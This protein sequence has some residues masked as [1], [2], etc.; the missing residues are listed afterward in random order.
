MELCDKLSISAK[1]NKH[2]LSVKPCCIIKKI[3]FKKILLS[4][5]VFMMLTFSFVP[6]AY[7][8]AETGKWYG[9]SF[10]EWFTK[11]DDSPE[12]EIFGERYTAAQVQCGIYGLFYFI[13]NGATNGNTAVLT[14]VMTKSL[15]DCVDAIKDLQVSLPDISQPTANA[16]PPQSPLL[17]VFSSHPISLYAW[18]SDVGQRLHLVP[19]VQAQGF[20]FQANNPTL[21]LWKISRNIT[22]SLLIIVIIALAFMIMFRVKISPQTVISVQSA[23]PKIVITLIL[24]TFSYAIA[25]LLIDLMYVVI[26]IVSALLTQGTNAISAWDWSTMFKALTTDRNVFL[27]LMY[28]Q[29][30]F[31]LTTFINIFSAAFLPGIFAFLFAIVS[32]VLLLWY[33]VKIIILLLKTYIQIMLLVIAAPFQILLGALVPG[34]GFGPWLRSMAANLAVYPLTGLF[35]VL[36]FIFLRAGMPDKLLGF[37]DVSGLA[38]TII[39]FNIN[40]G[41]LSGQPWDPPLT[42]GTGGADT[43]HFLWTIVSFGIIVL[44][45]KVAEIIQGLITGKPFPYGTAIAEALGPVKMGAVGGAQYASSTQQARY[46]ALQR[47]GATPTSAQ[48]TLNSIYDV[49]GRVGV[50]KRK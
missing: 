47:A 46:D 22:Y 33:S 23:L 37:I 38:T 44:L 40:N 39:P 24:I 26:G 9:Q 3:M 28:Y 35:F 31:I 45:P 25:G 49:L 14:C 6:L 27:L 11:V 50:V 36:A 41:F 34:T 12:S 32:G 7:A 20:G 43:S 19:R 21:S 1:S 15:D 42:F 29:L 4:F 16:S 13:L 18:L 10:E 48:Q 5:F 30:T 2:F 17:Q 8:Q